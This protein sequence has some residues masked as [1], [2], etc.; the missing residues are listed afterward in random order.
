MSKFETVY[1][2]K[3]LFHIHTKLK[4]VIREITLT[5]WNNVWQCLQSVRVKVW[6]LSILY[7]LVY[8]MSAI[9][10]L[11][12]INYLIYLH[13]LNH[14]GKLYL[15]KIWKKLWVIELIDSETVRTNSYNWVWTTAFSR[16]NINISSCNRKPKPYILVFSINTTQGLIRPLFQFNP[17]V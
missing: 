8:W 7:Q 12:N 10:P 15:V 16:F 17:S 3:I 5:A 4:C 6:L 9:L 2:K 1:L 13:F 11:H 14:A